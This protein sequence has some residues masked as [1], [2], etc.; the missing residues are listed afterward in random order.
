MKFKVCLFLLCLAGLVC[1]CR[2]GAV[3]QVPGQQ[4]FNIQYNQ[5]LTANNIT[6]NDS[7]YA[8]VTTTTLPGIVCVNQSTIKTIQALHTYGQ[9][10]AYQNGYYEGID[11]CLSN[12]GVRKPIFKRGPPVEAQSYYNDINNR[13]CLPIINDYIEMDLNKWKYHIFNDSENATIR[14]YYKWSKTD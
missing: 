7:K 2:P 12:I 10:W 3:C 13:I 14:F 8:L 4:G 6:R 11:D 9:A 5:F 1:A